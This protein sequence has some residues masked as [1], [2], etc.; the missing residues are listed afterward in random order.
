[1]RARFFERRPEKVLLT[2]ATLENVI[3]FSLFSRFWLVPFLPPSLSRF[4][5]FNRLY[6]LPLS[7][8]YLYFLIF[9]CSFFFLF[10]FV[11]YHI[12]FLLFSLISYSLQNLCLSPPFPSPSRSSPSILPFLPS[13][14]LTFLPFLSF[15]LFLYPSSFLSYTP[16]LPPKRLFISP[17][18]DADVPDDKG[19]QR[20]RRADE[21]RR[22][23]AR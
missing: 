15:S 7:F 12:C 17:F 22:V 19:L 1:M 9:H 5:S 10:V 21:N 2:R 23:E 11:F 18:P 4:L 8:C 3:S 14:S 16:P 6:S 13:P 20:V